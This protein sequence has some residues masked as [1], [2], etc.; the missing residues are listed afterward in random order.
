MKINIKVSKL[1][2]VLKKNNRVNLFHDTPCHGV[3]ASESYLQWL[4]R[5]RGLAKHDGLK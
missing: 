2:D 3:I 1:S 5:Q 4:P